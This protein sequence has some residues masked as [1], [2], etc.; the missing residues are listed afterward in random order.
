MEDRVVTVH[1]DVQFTGPMKYVLR[2]KTVDKKA[3]RKKQCNATR[4]TYDQKETDSPSLH[5]MR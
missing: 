5:R 3:T 2:T 1:V 4:C